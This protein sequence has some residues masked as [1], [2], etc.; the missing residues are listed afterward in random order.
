MDL[1]RY[2]LP[3]D[4]PH[5]NL[6]CTPSHTHTHTPLRATRP[7][8]LIILDFIIRIKFGEERKS[9]N[10]SLCSF[11]RFPVA[12]SLL[13]ILFS[14][15]ISVKQHVS[16]LYKRYGLV[17]VKQFLHRAK[18]TLKVSGGLSSQISWQ[19]AHEGGKISPTHRPHLPPQ[20]IS[21]VPISVTGWVVPRA[22]VRPEGLYQWKIPMTPSGIEPATFRLVAQ[23][24]HRSYVPPLIV[25]Q[26]PSLSLTDIFLRCSEMKR[27]PQP[28][29]FD[30][31]STFE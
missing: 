24:H 11:L 23:C 19:L 27:L 10:S 18:Q 15:T 29:D 22:K 2:L 31:L 16:Q 1:P 5:H 20:Q 13:S 14:N 3:S 8:H 28:L 21:L 17:K 7:A 30:F 12:S 4:F 25:L 9:W 26:P 6:V